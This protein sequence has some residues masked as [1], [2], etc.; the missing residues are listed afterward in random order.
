[1]IPDDPASTE[2]YELDELKEA[3]NLTRS[4]FGGEIRY[5]VLFSCYEILGNAVY[6]DK[7]ARG[8]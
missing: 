7:R 1:V 4:H 6:R 5:P 2:T 3:G 8:S